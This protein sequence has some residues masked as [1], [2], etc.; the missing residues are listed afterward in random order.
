[1]M[2]KIEKKD[3]CHFFVSLYSEKYIKNFLNDFFRNRPFFSVTLLHGL[4]FLKA[5][6]SL[7]FPLK[8][9]FFA[10]ISNNL[11]LHF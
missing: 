6:I 8:L 1:M 5:L 7:F 9:F 4:S 11:S 10:T 2:K 3:T